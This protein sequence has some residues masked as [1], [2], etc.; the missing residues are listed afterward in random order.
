VQGVPAGGSIHWVTYYLRHRRLAEELVLAR[1]RGVSVRVTLE[2]EPRTAQANKRVIDRLSGRDG[3][4]QGLR[5]VVHP[6]LPAPPGMV[7]RPHVHEKI[8]CFS[9]PQPVA[10]IGS[11][12]P[13]NDEPE[14]DPAL[15]REAGDMERGHNALVEIRN[16]GIVS[17]LIAH[18]RHMHASSHGLLERLHR[19][20]F[21]TLRADELEVHFWP[22]TTPHPVV[23]L[24]RHCAPRTRL[25]VAAS[26]IKGRSSTWTLSRLARR[27]VQIEILADASNRR[28]PRAAEQRLRAAGIG[29][30]RVALPEG[31]PMH[32]KFVLIDAPAAPRVIFGS[33][34]WTDR[35]RWLSH[36]VAAVSSSREVYEAFAERWELMAVQAQ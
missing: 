3:L 28:V 26:H 23:R 20:P 18:A 14:E 36:E 12:N 6:R 27:G 5:A 34:N 32:N 24:L 4:G 7:W 1:R 25:R 17:G 21:L 35:S 19:P 30:R 29:F 16:P 10:F 22:R 33:Y 15:A 31:L 9:H 13:V 2:G 8:Y 11:Y